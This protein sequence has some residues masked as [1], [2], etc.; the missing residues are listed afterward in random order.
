MRYLAVLAIAMVFIG[1]SIAAYLTVN[2]RRADAHV[3]LDSS[4]SAAIPGP[5]QKT[6]S[7]K[8]GVANM[9]TPIKGYDVYHGIAG[10]LAEGFGLPL[11]LIAAKTCAEMNNMLLNN[12]LDVAFACA[13]S[14]VSARDAMDVIAAGQAD[15]KPVYY[16]L[17]I[18]PADSKAGSLSD[19]KGK[20]FLYTDPNSNAGYWYAVRRLKD[21]GQ[22]PKTFF[23]SVK[24]TE[25]HD[26]S[27]LAVSQHMADGAVVS[28]MIYNLMLSKDPALASSVRVLEKSGPFPS[29][30]VVVRKDMPVRERNII[31]G[32]LF[33][34]SGSGQGRQMLSG[35][36][37]EGFVPADNSRYLSIK[38]A[39]AGE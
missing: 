22:E 9:V 26:H 15:G 36:G 19:L 10:K 39:E 4:P 33:N 30:P 35:I 25:S 14:P 31:L 20:N 29:P 2:Y 8:V 32:I 13:G 38:P 5:L 7:F 24:W 28:S 1:L 3:R 27:V 11:E 16:A 6:M 12:E 18:V 37:L 21:L 23:R 34:L 17:I